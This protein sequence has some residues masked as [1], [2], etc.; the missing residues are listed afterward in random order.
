MSAQARP[1]TTQDDTGALYFTPD[2][3][4]QFQFCLQRQERSIAT[5]HGAT[6]VGMLLTVAAS[7]YAQDAGHGQIEAD[8][9]TQACACM[10]RLF[11]DGA[12]P[13][14]LHIAPDTTNAQAT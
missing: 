10:S 6:S 2:A 13:D 5:Q 7:E 8:D 14:C 9:V 12:Q 11:G 1:L 3:L 4:R